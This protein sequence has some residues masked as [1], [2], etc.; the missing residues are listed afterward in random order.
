MATLPPHPDRRRKPVEGSPGQGR[1]AKRAL[2]RWDRN[3]QFGSG[4][5]GEPPAFHVAGNDFGR[6]ASV[7]GNAH[8]GRLAD[9][10]KARGTPVFTA[11]ARAL[12]EPIPNKEARA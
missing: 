3:E 2:T 11:P 5:R 10:I 6:R 7:A 9:S 8:S 1:R 12:S 4:L